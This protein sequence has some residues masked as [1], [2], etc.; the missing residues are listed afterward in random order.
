MNP[1]KPS[2]TVADVQCT[3]R[4]L[5]ELRAIRYKEKQALVERSLVATDVLPMDIESYEASISII[6][7]QTAQLSQLKVV[8]E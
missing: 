7:R 5:G 3:L 1:T 8:S 4:L 6:D 2:L